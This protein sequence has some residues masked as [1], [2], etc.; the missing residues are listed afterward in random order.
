MLFLAGHGYAKPAGPK[1][2]MPETFCFVCPDFDTSRPY[3]TGLHLADLSKL[4]ARIPCRKLVLL[5]CCHSGSANPAR[6]M[7]PDGV[8]PIILTA[9][10]ANEES[11]DIPYL[12]HG[13]FTAAVIEAL[14]DRF[15]AA[16]MDKDGML[17]VDEL[18]SYVSQRVPKI[19]ALSRSF[20][21]DDAV[22]T[23]AAFIPATV[24]DM[25][26]VR[27]PLPALAL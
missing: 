5:D 7:T 18:F 20:L 8:G 25:R 6:D 17:T 4:L 21:G 27:Q 12:A 13:A 23:P 14:G 22:Q 2:Y 19:V 16:D 15:A 10:G 11:H 9:C 3:T 1:V 26:I 24:K